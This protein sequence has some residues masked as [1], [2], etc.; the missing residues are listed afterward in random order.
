V[1]LRDHR[2]GSVGGCH[3]DHYVVNAIS[4]FWIVPGR[5]QVRGLPRFPSRRVSGGP[6]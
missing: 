3:A 5:L 6:R 4:G 2:V 1:T